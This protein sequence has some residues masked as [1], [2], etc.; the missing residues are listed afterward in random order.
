MDQQLG[1]YFQL[2]FDVGN[3]WRPAW[4]PDSRRIAFQTRAGLGSEAD[5]YI[6]SL[7]SESK[8]RPLVIGTGSNFYPTWSHDG[9][10]ILYTHL[11]GS[12]K[13]SE[14][15]RIRADGTEE[16]EPILRERFSVAFPSVSPDGRYVAYFS[17]RSGQGNIFVSS[18]PDGSRHARVTNQGA[19]W[20]KWRGDSIYFI[21]FETGN[22]MAAEVTT[23][24]V[25]RAG[26]PQ[27]VLT[28]DQAGAPFSV[29]GLFLWDVSADESEIVLIRDRAAGSVP[30]VVVVE[31][32]RYATDL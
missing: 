8:S 7:D 12:N 31:N 5:I 24:P 25:F 28:Q 9:E 18:Y 17:D 10:W 1:G 26:Q 16:P 29:P 32:W 2:T 19:G 4:S 6:Q 15:W 13:F 23:I 20:P 11:D 14:I 3:P 27:M 21:D 22:L 30:Q